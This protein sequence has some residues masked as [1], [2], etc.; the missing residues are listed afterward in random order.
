MTMELIDTEGQ[1]L[2]LRGPEPDDILPW[3]VLLANA[4]R[5]YGKP[6]WSANPTDK[7]I[8][9]GYAEKYK[10]GE[11]SAIYIHSDRVDMWAWIEDLAWWEKVSAAPDEWRLRP[12]YLGYPH[13]VAS[14]PVI[15]GIEGVRAVVIKHHTDK[16]WVKIDGRTVA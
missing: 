5:C 13:T 16:C 3:T 4:W 15:V 1:Q 10:I 2:L 12:E 8:E 11:I 6:L 9:S 7:E 14:T